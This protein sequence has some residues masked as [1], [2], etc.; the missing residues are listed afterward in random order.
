[1][2]V[3]PSSKRF[4]LVGCLFPG[5]W[6]LLVT[7]CGGQT[8]PPAPT[9]PGVGFAMQ[10]FALGESVRLVVVNAGNTVLPPAATSCRPSLQ[11][12]DSQGQLIKQKTVP[13]LA[14]G[15]ADI[16]D[17]GRNELPGIDRAEIRGVVKTGT[18]GSAAAPDGTPLVFTCNLLVTLEIFDSNTGRTILASTDSKPLPSSTVPTQ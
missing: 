6:M 3:Q 11:F 2:L 10:G 4:F 15:T 17:L 13:D 12:Y 14:A 1:M 8:P 9:A 7:P 16:L 18:S 5:L